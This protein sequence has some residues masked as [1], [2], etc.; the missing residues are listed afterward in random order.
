VYFALATA[1]SIV[2]RG[3]KDE[4]RGKAR[5]AALNKPIDTVTI[6]PGV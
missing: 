2:H 3:V 4:D 1:G 6:T 5:A